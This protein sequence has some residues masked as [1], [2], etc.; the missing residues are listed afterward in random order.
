MADSTWFKYIFITV[1]SGFFL[2]N[3]KG[4]NKD[5]KKKVKP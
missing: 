5:T 1:T 2:K 4:K 3:E